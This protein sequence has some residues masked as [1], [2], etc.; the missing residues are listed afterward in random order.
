M[1][2]SISNLI[3]PTYVLHCLY[4]PTCHLLL[5]MLYS[6]FRNTRPD[7]VVALVAAGAALAAGAFLAAA[8]VTPFLIVFITVLLVEAG[9]GAVR[10]VVVAAAR[11][12]FRTTVDVLP[13]LDSLMALTLRAVRVVVGAV[14]VLTAGLVVVVAALVRVRDAA[15]L[16]AA[17]LAVD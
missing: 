13:S 15:V 3:N 14:D 7:L 12:I 11:P 2:A 1:R 10:V 16:P 8:P 4:M 17:E 5:P 9:V 6:R